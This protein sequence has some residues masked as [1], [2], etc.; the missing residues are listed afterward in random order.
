MSIRLLL[1]LLAISTLLPAQ[2]QEGPIR[3]R[4]RER[5]AERHATQHAAPA[6]NPAISGPGDYTFTLDVGSQPRSFRVHVP[7][8]YVAGQSAPLLVALHGGGG[9]RGG[10]AGLPTS[11]STMRTRRSAR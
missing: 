5:W 10:S 9:T 8:S 4:L 1:M 11:R 7:R 3:Q 2:A 6:Q